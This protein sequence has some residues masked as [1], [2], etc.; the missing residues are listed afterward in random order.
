MPGLAACSAP[1]C[2]TPRL[3]HLRLLRRHLANHPIRHRLGARCAPH[4]S[5]TARPLPGLSRG[6]IERLTPQ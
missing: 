6:Q 5:S 4:R 2:S 1:G 3:L